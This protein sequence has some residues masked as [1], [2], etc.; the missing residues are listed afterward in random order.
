MTE[1][2][3]TAIT[4]PGHVLVQTIGTGEAVMLN[5]ENESYFGLNAVAS[6]MIEVLASSETLDAA[7]EI[8]SHEY[9]VDPQTLLAD[10]GELVTELESR[11]LI[12]QD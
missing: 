9:E 4:I 8:L 7:V 5:L 3:P 12:T 11:G 1:Q 2:Q 10:I 6:R